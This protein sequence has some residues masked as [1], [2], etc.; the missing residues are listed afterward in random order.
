MADDETVERLWQE[1]L[2]GGHP[3]NQANFDKIASYSR[4]AIDLMVGVIV[5]SIVADVSQSEREGHSEQLA[6]ETVEKGVLAAQ[7]V[8]DKILEELERV[9][10]W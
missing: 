6:A 3:I 4:H 8:L 1:A 10:E 7:Q 5:C 9:R 2:N